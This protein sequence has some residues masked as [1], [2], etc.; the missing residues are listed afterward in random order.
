MFFCQGEEFRLE[1]HRWSLR[2]NCLLHTSEAAS[3]RGRG[4]GTF[5][6]WKDSDLKEQQVAGVWTTRKGQSIVGSEGERLGKGKE[7][8]SPEE[9][10]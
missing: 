7:L 6:T 5:L 4:V 1:T 10:S 2:V 3:G 8:Y 9:D